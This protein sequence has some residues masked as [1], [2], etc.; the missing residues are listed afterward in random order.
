MSKAIFSTPISVWL[1]AFVVLLGAVLFA[2]ELGG[3]VGETIY[4]YRNVLLINIVIGLFI[5]LSRL[6]GISF[7]VLGVIMGVAGHLFFGS[8]DI[9]PVSFRI[10]VML[11]MAFLLAADT[12]TLRRKLFRSTLARDLVM[13][14]LVFMIWTFLV[15][16][17][18]GDSLV[19]TATFMMSNHLFALVSFIVIQNRL[20]TQKHIVLFA[21][22]LAL[23]ALL[24]ALFA[25][26]QWFGIDKAWEVAL[27]LRPGE[28]EALLGTRFGDF[29]FVPGL[30][31]FSISLSYV[32]ISLGFFVYSWTIH[33]QRIRP[34]FLLIGVVFTGVI[35]LG[36]IFSQSRSA[37]GATAVVVLVSL[38]LSLGTRGQR[39]RAGA[40]GLHNYIIAIG[41]LVVILTFVFGQLGRFLDATPE[42]GGGGYSLGRVFS[43][44]DPRRVQAAAS[45]LELLTSSV[46][47]LLIGSDGA[48]YD[49]FL[50]RR[51]GEDDIVISPHNLFLNA[52]VLTGLPGVLLV[53]LLLFGLLKLGRAVI[54]ATAAHDSSVR[55][56]GMGAFY[57]LLAYV[58]NAQFHNSGFVSGDAM[59]WWLIGL[60]VAIVAYVREQDKLKAQNPDE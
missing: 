16:Q 47:T 18:H 15:R 56:V 37:I 14:Y 32:L 34:S 49:E 12:L 30:S 43:L 44:E 35:V 3:I 50:A 45:S 11:L 36:I 60:M 23:A 54:R 40:K 57:G 9:G 22:A 2:S 21:S 29:G 6:M 39:R 7:N 38:V 46:S 42:A 24:S 53:V 25:V 59:P 8:L 5:P 13:I 10:Y 31:L 1:I 28:E 4:P 52:A 58:L 33:R 26:G 20:V 19:G 55:W 41:L 27:A 17:A 51:L 48:T